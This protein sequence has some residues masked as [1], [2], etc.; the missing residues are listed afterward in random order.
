[1]LPLNSLHSSTYYRLFR[2]LLCLSAGAATQQKVSQ[3]D[4]SLSQGDIFMT[5]QQNKLTQTEMK[6]EH[7]LICYSL[8]PYV[9][10]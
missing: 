8:N 3:A 10:P 7:S 9:E 2:P 1:M 4:G 6:T 5:K